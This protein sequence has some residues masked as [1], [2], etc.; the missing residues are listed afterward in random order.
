MQSAQPIHPPTSESGQTG[1]FLTFQLADQEYGLDILSV[2]EIRGW[3]G[4]TPLPNV[5]AYVR[6]VINLRGA[7]VP[8]IDLR[9]RFGLEALEYG[10]ATVVIVLRANHRGNSGLG[11]FGIVVDAVAEVYSIEAEV[12][13]PTPEFGNRIDRNF[14]QG[15]ATLEDNLIILL[16]IDRLLNHDA[17]VRIANE[18]DRGTEEQA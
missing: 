8:I 17:E 10:P 2:R 6:G 7:I 18:R 12:I 9:A 4:V 3:S 16:D 13:K 15:L 14:V 5:P 11:E 1:Q